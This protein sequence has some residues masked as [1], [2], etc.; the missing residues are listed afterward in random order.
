M[1]C[2]VSNSY[3]LRHEEGEAHFVETLKKKKGRILFEPSFS[4]SPGCEYGWGVNY[5]FFRKGEE[6]VLWGRDSVGGVGDVST[7]AFDWTIL[8]QSFLGLREV[9]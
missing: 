2:Y 1:S 3:D 7:A 9:G 6:S 8:S 5:V 4:L